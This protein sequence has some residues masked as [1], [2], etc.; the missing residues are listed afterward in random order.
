M[1]DHVSLSLI[2]PGY[3]LFP[4][5][6]NTNNITLWLTPGRKSAGNLLFYFVLL[7]GSR[8]VAH[9]GQQR[10]TRYRVSCYK[11]EECQSATFL[12]PLPPII[13]SLPVPWGHIA[14]KAWGD[15]SGQRVLALHGEEEERVHSVMVL[16]PPH[17]V[18]G[19]CWVI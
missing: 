19:Q 8:H 4:L 6:V 7:C 17:R 9:L 16:L 10:I 5:H 2:S 15:P 13:V 12:F 3:K 11:R 14:G 1:G 18:A